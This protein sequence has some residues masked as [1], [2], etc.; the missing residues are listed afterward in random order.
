MPSPTP[1]GLSTLENL[2]TLCS[3][4]GS[5]QDSQLTLLL[6]AASSQ[7]E[8]YCNRRFGLRTTT[9]KVRG[10]GRD[11]LLLS[12]WPIVS[13]TS[14]TVDGA[15]VTDYELRDANVPD[16]PS[17]LWRWYG[18][19]WKPSTIADVTTDPDAQSSDL[20]ITVV[21]VAG[22]KLPGVTYTG[23]YS[24]A[25]IAAASDLPSDIE[26]ASLRQAQYLFI[27]RPGYKSERTPGGYSYDMA[28]PVTGMTLEPEV[29]AMLDPYR[30]HY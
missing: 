2:K 22:Y 7:V 27:R 24:N 6:K 12:V 5:T 14:V 16:G 17:H 4:S 23:T 30:R 28:T 25:V 20:N 1:V 10:T 19:R 21:Y 18:W 3:V 15:A 26:L 9:E 8:T 13:V 11:F 29:Q